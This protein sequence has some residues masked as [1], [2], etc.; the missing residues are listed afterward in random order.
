M[1]EMSSD[2][3]STQFDSHTRDAET[4]TFSRVTQKKFQKHLTDVGVQTHMLIG[5]DFNAKDGANDE[6]DAID[7]N[8]VGGHASGKTAEDSGSGTGH[9]ST[10]C[11]GKHFLRTNKITTSNIPLN[12]RLQTTRQLFLDLRSTI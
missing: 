6:P 12:K 5:G 3:K 4:G 2:H 9:F 10:S 1:S 7:S 11:T 8:Y